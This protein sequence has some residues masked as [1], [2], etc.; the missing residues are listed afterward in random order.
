MSPIFLL[1]LSQAVTPHQAYKTPSL[2]EDSRACNGLSVVCSGLYNPADLENDLK[3][4]RGQYNPTNLKTDLGDIAAKAG[5]MTAMFLKSYTQ[6]IGAGKGAPIPTLTTQDVS[7]AITDFLSKAS[8]EG[9]HLNA[10]QTL[11][12]RSLF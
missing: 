2:Y 7:T 12:E 5:N 11:I 6:S 3:A 8:A 9:G 10:S 1:A 4:V